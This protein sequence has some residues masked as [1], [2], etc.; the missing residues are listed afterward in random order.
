MGQFSW[1]DCR[2]GS[3]ILDNVEADV[4]LLVPKEFGGGRIKETCYDGYGNFGGKDAYDLVADWNREFL[5]KNPNHRLPHADA[6]TRSYEWYGK[7]ADLSA[8]REEVVGSM[9]SGYAEWRGIG[10]DLACYDEDNASLPYPIKITHDSSAVY[11]ECGPS[12]SDPD[13]GWLMDDPYDEED[14]WSTTRRLLPDGS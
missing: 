10:I 12:P 2:D 14:W 6:E 5:S 1:L 4:Y 7:Y 13:Q 8:S 3:Q 9:K 11:E